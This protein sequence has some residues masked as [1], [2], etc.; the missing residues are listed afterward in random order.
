MS[1]DGSSSTAAFTIAVI[2]VSEFDLTQVA[3]SDPADNAL[4]ENAPASSYTGIT[5]SATDEDRS[6]VVTYALVDSN[7]GLFAADT[8]TGVVTLR[9][10]LDYELSTQHTIIGQAISSDASD[11]TTAAFTIVVTDVN[12]YVV[13]EVSD[14][15]PVENELPESS[16]AGA[17]ANITLSA[18]DRDGTAIV[19]YALLDSSD[20][21]FVAD[22]DTGV[23]TLQRPA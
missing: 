18:T 2:D 20:G 1:D 5:L 3:D 21:L 19:T 7:D 17:P 23:V 8:D 4:P 13:G 9:G 22:T 12:E 15:D 11:P 16:T 14:A 10:R 6:A